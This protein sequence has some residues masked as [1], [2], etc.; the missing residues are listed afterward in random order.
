MNRAGD[1]A[2]QRQ[3]FIP[4]SVAP[5]PR[6]VPSSPQMTTPPVLSSALSR[7]SSSTLEIPVSLGGVVSLF[8]F[9]TRIIYS[10]S[11]T[12]ELNSFRPYSFARVNKRVLPLDHEPSTEPLSNLAPLYQDYLHYHYCYCKPDFI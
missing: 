11:P 3:V 6:H 7:P 12:I 9:Y 10:L 1:R 5:S 4:P 2:G 8:M